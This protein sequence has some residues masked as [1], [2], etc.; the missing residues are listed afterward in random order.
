MRTCGAK[1]RRGTPCKQ[2]AGWGTDHPG[3]G[4]CKLHGGASPRGRDHP[5]FKHGRWSRYIGKSEQEEYEE[6]CRRWELDADFEEEIKI[7]L[8]RGY[9]AIARGRMTVMTSDGPQEVTPDPKY[10]LQCMKLTVG[11]L[12]KLRESRDGV[13]VNVRLA[14][15]AQQ[16]LWRAVGAAIAEHVTDEEQQEAL[17][18]D[19]E[20][21]AQDY[22]RQKA[23]ADEGNENLE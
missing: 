2:P 5:S 8:F 19:I 11:S 18:A 16:A 13:T 6:F 14:D 20:E 4:R 15:E 9:R 10:A 3:E 1:T 21:L 7:G 22:E 17:L 12:A 23:A